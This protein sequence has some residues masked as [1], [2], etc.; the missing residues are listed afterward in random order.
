MGNLIK[1]PSGPKCGSFVWIYFKY[2]E[3][4]I[5]LDTRHSVD[6]EGPHNA[7]QIRNIALKMLAIKE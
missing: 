3:K 4:E 5:T 1:Q 7:P 2:E 6:A